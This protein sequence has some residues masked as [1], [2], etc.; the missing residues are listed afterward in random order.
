M[1]HPSLSIPVAQGVSGEDGPLILGLLPLNVNASAF[2]VIDG[3]LPQITPPF[4]GDTLFHGH[5]SAEDLLGPLAGGTLAD[6]EEALASG[7]TQVRQG[8]AGSSKGGSQIRKGEQAMPIYRDWPVLK[9]S[10]SLSSH[11]A[12][13]TATC[14]WSS[15]PHR[16]QAA[17]CGDR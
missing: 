6:L 7:E 10:E 16:I 3:P 15:I 9:G 5:S 12:V 8:E 11:S 1:H 14:R 2:D 4:T 13:V 17:S